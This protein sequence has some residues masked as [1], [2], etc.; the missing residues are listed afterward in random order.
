MKY[1]F[2]H[3]LGQKSDSWHKVTTFIEDSNNVICPDLKM[4]LEGKKATYHNLYQSLE[5][6]CETFEEPLCLIGLSLGGMLALQYTLE[7]KSK[8]SLLVLIGT[9]YKAPKLL[10]FLQNIIFKLIPENKFVV[11][12]FSKNEFIDLCKS[13]EQLDFSDELSNLNC[14]TLIV[15]GQQDKANLPAAKRMAD[16]LPNAKL[17]IIP[18]ASHEVNG[19]NSVYLQEVLKDFIMDNI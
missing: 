14:K 1:I 10:L 17:N 15:C 5:S 11:E 4:L 18:D 6:L 13:M 12:G 3:G 7:H 8:V 9:Q 16:I 19:D 2:L